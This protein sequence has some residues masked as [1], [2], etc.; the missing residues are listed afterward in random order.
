M[1]STSR[2]LGLR[3][4]G[5]PPFP[6]PEV[7]MR[8]RTS[9]LLLLALVASLLPVTALAPA[10]AQQA[11][12]GDVVISQVYGGGG[13][14]GAPF[15]HDY[16]ELL[17]TGASPVD[18]GGWSLQYTSATGTSWGGQ[19]TALSGSIPPGGYH[20]VRLAGGA[21]GAALPTPDD[22]GSTNM[23]ATNGKVALVSST[24]ALPAE[25]CPT[26]DTIV[27][28][29]GFGSANCFEGTAGAP[30]LSN[31]TAALRADGGCTDTDDNAADFAAGTPTPRNASST[32][33]VC[34][35]DA[36]Q[37][38]VTDCPALTVPE[39]EAATTTLRASDA[40]GT[41]TDASVTGSTAGVTFA[42]LTPASEVGGTATLEVAVADTVATGSYDFSVTFT[43]DDPEPQTA[44]CT[45]ELTVAGDPC[46]APTLIQ[47]INTVGGNG[48]PGRNFSGEVRTVEGVVTADF[49]DGLQGFFVQEEDADA[50][51]ATT[52]TGVFVYAPSLTEV[53]EV[54]TLVCVTGTVGQFNGL[55]QLTGQPTVVEVAPNQPLPTTVEL[56]L[57]VE[58]RAV[59]GRYAGMHV[60]LSSAT[61]EFT[62]A[63]NY[64]QGQYGELDLTADG[65]QWNPTELF[66]PDD[67]RALELRA[68]NL[69]AQIKLDD[70]N[71]SQNRRPI[72]WLANGATRAGATTDADLAGVLGYQFNAW[73]IQP[74]DPDAIQ[75]VNEDNPRPDGAP[76]VLGTAS[77]DEA[78]TVAAFNVLNYFTTLTQDDPNARG[79]DTPEEFELQ[80][81]KIVT[82]ITEMDA[83]VVA[84]IEIENNFG[85]SNDA[86]VDLVERLNAVAGEGAYAAI[87]LEDRVGSDAISN[88]MIYQPDAVTPVGEVGL[89]EQQAFVNPRGAATDRSRPAVAQA[90]VAG[91]S[92]P[93][94]VVSNHLKSKG[95]GCGAGD[96]HP[97][98]ASCNLTRTLASEELVR[99]LDEDDPTGTGAEHVVV[100]GDLNAYA[101]EDPIE[102][103]RDAGYVD[104]LGDQLGETYSYV[105][106]SELGRLDHAFVSESLAP[107][108]VDAAVWHI[109]ADEPN[110]FDY[111]D[112]NDP[113]TQDESEFRSS[114][115]DPVLVGLDLAEPVEDTYLVCPPGSGSGFGDVPADS[116]HADS[117]RC[118]DALEL[119]RGK[120]DGRFDP[121][122]SLTRG[123]AASVLDRVATALQRPIDG[124]RRSFAD[125][126]AGYAHADAIDRLGGAGVIA[127]YT[128]GTF[129]PQ[130]PVDR[131]QLASLVV[132]F[133]ETTAGIELPLGAPFVDV[134]SD[135][136]HATALRKARE[137]GIVLGDD[138][139]RADPRSQIRRDQAAS[140]FVRSLAWLPI[141]NG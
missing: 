55:T 57:P 15:T 43:N 20:L 44:T 100:T 42:D 68:D 60:E 136:P 86:L 34:D 10:L 108:V 39:G 11:D 73:R 13:N 113:A 5:D 141:D 26:H 76:D 63:Q 6:P 71:G 61:G 59:Y 122:G 130:E 114:D 27:D 85:A 9:V 94:V 140:L 128:D 14:S 8:R 18:V 82:A 104:A 48:L 37:P 87:E 97:M 24:T 105:F 106:D 101:M 81:A 64:F 1:A 92:D 123:Q 30:E 124:Q 77:G 22:T 72:P 84:L 41:V 46:E 96:D 126:P 66:H 23:S 80:A 107:H 132:R 116:P 79:A 119:F 29:V 98:A 40:D 58:D 38:I 33:N 54:G 49:Q 74:T 110:A 12:P 99:W 2:H 19:T 75:F 16:V 121:R 120:T 93:F 3:G 28:L 90:F 135:S 17:N 83:D 115:H 70:A 78:V 91:D 31:T 127:G 51:G 134:P 45:F 133:V 25:T 7:P 112:W 32:P 35:P 131:D 53:P 65:R 103:L 47:D 88:A 125:V 117:V 36:P 138:Q 109:N 50:V 118:G 129:R 69:R 137:A 102:V 95:S 4:C 139:G 21:S 111:N 67:P 52:S 56:E 62:L 89:A